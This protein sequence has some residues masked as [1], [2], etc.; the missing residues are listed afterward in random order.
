[1]ANVAA[2]IFCTLGVVLAAGVAMLLFGS[3]GLV[4]GIAEAGTRFLRAS[5]CVAVWLGNV[6]AGGAAGMGLV[7]GVATVA[8]RINFWIDEGWLTGG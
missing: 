1:M 5:I 7:G 3:W 6:G 4:A 2:I 8:G